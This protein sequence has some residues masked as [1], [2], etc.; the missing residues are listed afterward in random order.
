[1][2][3]YEEQFE[4]VCG[5]RLV[6]ECHCN[7]FAWKKALDALVAAFASDIVRKLTRKALEGKSGWDDPDWTTEQIEQALRD[8]VDK[9]D[10]VDVAN[11]A[12]FLWNR[13]PHTEDKR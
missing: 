8:H 10:P 4:V 3:F 7:D 13:Q 11:F 9:G 6:G 1:M 5:C 12:M 2:K